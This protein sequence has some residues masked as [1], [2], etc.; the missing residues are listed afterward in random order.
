MAY[1]CE[2][3]AVMIRHVL[4]DARTTAERTYEKQHGHKAKGA[5]AQA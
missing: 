3:L 5:R 1:V 4:P 2:Q